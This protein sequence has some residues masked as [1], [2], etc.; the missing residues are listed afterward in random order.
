MPQFDPTAAVVSDD[1]FAGG[2]IEIEI[3]ENLEDADSLSI[4]SVGPI[5]IDNATGIVTYNDP[6]DG[7]I[8]IGIVR[9]AQNGQ[10]GKAQNT[11][12]LLTQGPQQTYYQLLILKLSF[13]QGK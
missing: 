1:E 6:D 13:S 8:E 12:C 5:S 3:S 2:S 10:N 7:L 11:V 9:E 4:R